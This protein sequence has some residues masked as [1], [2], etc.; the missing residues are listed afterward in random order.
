MGWL[1]T[2]LI[3][4][5]LLPPLS[6]LLI[7]ALGLALLKRR[8]GLGKG[9]LALSLGLLTVLSLPAVSDRLLGSLEEGTLLPPEHRPPAQAIVV[10]GGGR[11]I[12][13]LEYAGDTVG[14]VTLRRVR[15]GAW[16]QRETG[17]P[18]LVT[19]GKPDG[20][21]L[22]EGETMRR[23]LEREFGV[24]VRWV[25]DRSDNTRENAYNSRE[26]LKGSGVRTIYLVTHAWHM[27]RAKRVFETAGFKVV[28]A[29]I[30]FH[31]TKPLT[32]L[33]FLPDAKALEGSSHYIH[34]IIG[35]VWY[36]LKS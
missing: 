28:P 32:V 7:G 17:L 4:S 6:L 14:S 23:V 9:L 35:L 18:L 27:P 31:Q 33:D 36:R 16:L 20:G 3:A 30:G 11:D 2:N 12:N 5:F 34:E 19:G 15:Y 26:L 10:L 8:P 22:S 25:E 24:P 21:T 29:G 13:A 1:L